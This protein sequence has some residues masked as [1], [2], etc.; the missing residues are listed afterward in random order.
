M[1]EHSWKHP[2][3]VMC[4]IRDRVEE[5]RMD[6]GSQKKHSERKEILLETENMENKDQFRCPVTI[7]QKKKKKDE[8]REQEINKVRVGSGRKGS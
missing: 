2:W 4:S 7:I 8:L 5:Q 1:P 3:A 6:L